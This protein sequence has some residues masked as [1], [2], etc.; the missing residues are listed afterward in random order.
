[1]AVLGPNG[2]FPDGTSPYE[3]ETDEEI[4]EA[5]RDGRFKGG[6]KAVRVGGPGFF[7]GSKS[8]DENLLDF[9]GSIGALGGTAKESYEAKH[10]KE[11]GND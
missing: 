10:K 6:A 8:G 4:R 11:N 2:R 5:M 9:L 3:G 7:T 1:M